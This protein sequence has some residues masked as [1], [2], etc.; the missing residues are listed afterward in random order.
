[1]AA[2]LA[3]ILASLDNGVRA[4]NN[5]RSQLGAI[6]PGVTAV[7]TAVRGSVG[8][9]TFNSSQATGFISVLSASG[10]TYYLATYPSS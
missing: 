3:D 4:I 9:I 2:S 7:S 6:F 1:M 8:T 5:L 10:A